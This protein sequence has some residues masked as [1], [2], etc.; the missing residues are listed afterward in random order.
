MWLLS[1]SFME[2]WISAIV[3]MRRESLR[4]N[5]A[6]WSSRIVIEDSKHFVAQGV[7]PGRTAG[8]PVARALGA[9]LAE[10]RVL[11]GT[12]GDDAVMNVALVAARVEATQFVNYGFM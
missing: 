4:W 6:L 2:P 3:R 8:P 12:G 7:G 9:S 11:P 1:G 5:H 10:R